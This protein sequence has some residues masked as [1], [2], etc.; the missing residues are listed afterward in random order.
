[1]G[2]QVNNIQTNKTIRR[3]EEEMKLALLTTMTIYSIIVRGFTTPSFTVRGRLQQQ[4]TIPLCN[5]L[6]SSN[7]KGSSNS[8]SNSNT[9]IT[10]CFSTKMDNEEQEKKKK[11]PPPPMTLLSGFLGSG[12]TTLLQHLLNNKQG[13]K[14]A[15]IVN[16]VADI[17]SDSKLIVGQT[18]A[19]NDSNSGGKNQAP[20]GIVQ[21]SN[22]CACCSLADELLPSISELILLNISLT[23]NKNSNVELGSPCFA[24]YI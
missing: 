18:V 14:I 13:L 6:H 22:G 8:N 15:V 21:L 7:T 24:P 3:Q 12:K 23:R 2:S 9:R 1:M 5:I 17:N 4:H 11:I 20:A 10:K 16:D 19:S